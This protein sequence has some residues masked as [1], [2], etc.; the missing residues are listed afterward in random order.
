MANS[1]YKHEFSN[2]RQKGIHDVKKGK[3]RVIVANNW[4]IEVPSDIRIVRIIH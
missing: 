3:E 1:I 2:K 4:S